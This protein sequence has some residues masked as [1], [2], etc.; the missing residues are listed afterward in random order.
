MK[1]PVIGR[2]VQCFS[3]CPSS[4]SYEDLSEDDNQRLTTLRGDSLKCL[5]KP[6]AAAMFVWSASCLD[7]LGQEELSTSH[8]QV[9][10]Q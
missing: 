8:L 5:L 4:C 6:A 1:T 7:T 3:Q 10:A 9:A 2:T